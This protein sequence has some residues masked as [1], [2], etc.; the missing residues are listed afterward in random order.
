MPSVTDSTS[1]GSPK[2]GSRADA[3][4]AV[5]PLASG[6]RGSEV[7]HEDVMPG[8][9]LRPVVHLLPWARDAALGTEGRHRVQ[10]TSAPLKIGDKE[11]VV[12]V[13]AERGTV[14]ERREA[15]EQ[16]LAMAQTLGG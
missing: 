13:S 9:A 14:V 16:R 8:S 6:E 10:P 1:G 4:C 11:Y 5:D 7:T 2:P 12:E 15:G 3:V